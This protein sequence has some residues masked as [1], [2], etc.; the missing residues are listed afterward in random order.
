MIGCGNNN[1]N[2]QIEHSSL[3][4]IGQDLNKDIFGKGIVHN[5]KTDECLFVVNKEISVKCE[6]INHRTFAKSIMYTC[7][8][9]NNKVKIGMFSCYDH[10][11]NQT[12]FQ[13]ICS[14]SSINDGY[15]LRKDN[16]FFWLNTSG[17]VLKLGITTDDKYL[18]FDG[19]NYQNSYCYGFRSA[20][21]MNYFQRL[22]YETYDAF[23]E[24]H[25]FKTRS[26]S[27][28]FGGYSLGYYFKYMDIPHKTIEYGYI[29]LDSGSINISLNNSGN[30]HGIINY[31]E[32]DTH[33]A[34]SI[35]GYTCNTSG[36]DLKKLT[37]EY[38][39]FC[40]I[41]ETFNGKK[42][43]FKNK[44]V[45]I[46]EDNK[47]LSFGLVSNLID[48][49]QDQSVFKCAEVLLEIAFIKESGFD[50]IDEYYEAKEYGLKTKKE[51]EIHKKAEAKRT[52]LSNI[53]YGFLNRYKNSSNNLERILVPY[54]SSIEEF[55][56]FNNN[57]GLNLENIWNGYSVY[58]ISATF[59]D[60]DGKLKSYRIH[61]D[62]D[63][64]GT[65]KILTVDE[66]KSIIALDCGYD[67]T[68]PTRDGTYFNE[69]DFSICS[70]SQSRSGG[71]IISYAA[72][73][74]R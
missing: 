63:I 28:K 7:S 34:A 2:T 6:Y 8:E 29:M 36:E 24:D 66:I 5:E 26:D 72:K 13:K 11:P 15:Y 23:I 18:N 58:S 67:W 32:D 39:M 57:G 35:D 50:D 38:K 14:P 60:S 17:Q 52:Q 49:Y 68:N 70:I 53:K 37:S 54:I 20:T 30:I 4:F 56:H 44:A 3:S 9:K 45:F 55:R 46:L 27:L 21:Q 64:F 47:I 10:I 74:I 1:K 59:N 16:S 51:Y 42:H 62:F 19:N 43:Y 40:P 12:E 61:V 22:G 41:S 33:N 71:L 69:H 65:K 31:C 48:F 73:S 25:P